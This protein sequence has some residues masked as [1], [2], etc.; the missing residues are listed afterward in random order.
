[1]K[2]RSDPQMSHFLTNLA[3]VLDMLGVI[4]FLDIGP[5]GFKLVDFDDNTL[6]RVG[7]VV[8]PYSGEA[9]FVC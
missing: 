7:V 8:S 1:M 2:Q 4:F 3:F 6:N 5:E 9:A